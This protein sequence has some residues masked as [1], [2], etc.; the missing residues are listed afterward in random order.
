M[1]TRRSSTKNWLRQ[2]ATDPF[3][4]QRD[5]AGYRS[6]A[7]FKLKEILA[8]DRLITKG[9]SVL[10]LGASPG[11]WTQVAVSA[12]GPKGKVVAVDILPMEPIAGAEFIEGDCREAET[13]LKITTH[14]GAAPIGLVISDIAP[15][16]TGIRDVDAA[17]F[18]E[19]AE[20]VRDISV[21][22]LVPGGALVI[23]LFQFPGTDEYI[24][25]LKK[26]FTSIARRKPAAS[27]QGSREIY[28]VAKGFKI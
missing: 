25:E 11:G 23:K 19:L 13:L 22:L 16:I 18:L 6:R 4:K 3:V 20:F 5:Q 12:V 24:G 2:Q 1:S 9:G 8:R 28:V 21:K 27:R 7:A 14:F 15:N 17:N 26:I 10:D